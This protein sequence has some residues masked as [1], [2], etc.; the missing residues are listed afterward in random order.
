MLPQSWVRKD[1]YYVLMI[2]LDGAG[3]T[4]VEA[5]SEYLSGG[6]VECLGRTKRWDRLANWEE[7]V[8]VLIPILAPPIENSL[9]P[10]KGS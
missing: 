7:A 3:K 10:C 4:T 8:S 6:G 5:W 1:E 2:G 9:N